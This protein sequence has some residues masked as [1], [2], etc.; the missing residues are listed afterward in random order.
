M[1]PKPPFGPTALALC[2][3]EH[4][5]AA[6]YCVRSVAPGLGDGVAVDWRRRIPAAILNRPQ[7]RRN[8]A[9]QD[10]GGLFL[11]DEIT[12]GHG[13]AGITPKRALFGLICGCC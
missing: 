10:R 1:G 2:V 5:S 9:I 12:A 6:A 8:T 3:A 7:N 4:Q 11:S 13:A